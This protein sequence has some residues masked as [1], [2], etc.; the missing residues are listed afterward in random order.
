MQGDTKEYMYK[1]DMIV[2]NPEVVVFW[3]AVYARCRKVGQGDRQ[4]SGA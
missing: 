4:S 3:Q 1:Y 2:D